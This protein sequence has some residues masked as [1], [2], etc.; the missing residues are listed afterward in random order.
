MAHNQRCRGSSALRFPSESFYGS[1]DHDFDDDF[2]GTSSN[3][4]EAGESEPS[5]AELASLAILESSKPSDFMDGTVV[6]LFDN[7]DT[8]IVAVAIRGMP[9]HA[10]EPIDWLVQTVCERF[11]VASVLLGQYRGADSSTNVT[12]TYVAVGSDQLDAWCR[13]AASLDARGIALRDIF[14]CESWASAASYFA[15]F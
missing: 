1:F 14:V 6:V 7:L 3:H 11:T 4:D 15:R 10:S 9:T 13:I 2:D 8:P 12:P 5:A